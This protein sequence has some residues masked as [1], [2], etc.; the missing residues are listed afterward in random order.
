M[1]FLGIMMS[2]KFRTTEFYENHIIEYFT[3]VK[4]IYFEMLFYYDKNLFY[5]HVAWP[6]GKCLGHYKYKL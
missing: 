2:N 4:N 3:L 1:V 5:V 6:M